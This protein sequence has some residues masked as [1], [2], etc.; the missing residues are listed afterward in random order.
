MLAKPTSEKKSVSQ[1]SASK[2]E[3]DPAKDVEMQS[4][5]GR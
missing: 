2:K 4:D 1:R 5:N 3:E